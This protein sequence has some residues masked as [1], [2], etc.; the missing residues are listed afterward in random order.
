MNTYTVMY[1]YSSGIPDKDTVYHST[2][3]ESC[4]AGTSI[5]KKTRSILAVCHRSHGSY[6]RVYIIPAIVD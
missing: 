2:L 6:C 1:T 4:Q 5:Q 3:Q